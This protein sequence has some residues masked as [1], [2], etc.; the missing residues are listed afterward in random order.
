MLDFKDEM[1]SIYSCKIEF[2]SSMSI[3]KFLHKLFN[4]FS[5]CTYIRDTFFVTI[6]STILSILFFIIVIIAGTIYLIETNIG[7]T[8]QAGYWINNKTSI[9]YNNYTIY[10]YNIS[11]V[12]R[13][14][15]SLSFALT[16]YKNRQTNST[17]NIILSSISTDEISQFKINYNSKRG[18]IYWHVDVIVI[19]STDGY[20][21]ILDKKTNIPIS[22][23]NEVCKK[24]S[25]INS[26]HNV[27][28]TWIF[29]P[30]F[31]SN[32][33][34]L[35]GA[36]YGFLYAYNTNNNLKNLLEQPIKYDVF[37]SVSRKN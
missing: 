25:L 34:M 36:E 16:N 8:D 28:L 11:I 17:N 31:R 21:C 15:F 37:I 20:F 13:S 32:S 30:D 35:F 18:G 33:N 19:V 12:S 23:I 7:S 22:Q 3:N 14:E 4:V 6:I 1:Y 2:S 5:K 9:Y 24:N 10:C 27:P 29:E 26:D